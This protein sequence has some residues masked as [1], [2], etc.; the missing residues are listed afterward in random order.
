MQ[1]TA[2]EQTEE[3]NQ[4]ERD[5][6]EYWDRKSHHLKSRKSVKIFSSNFGITTFC[7]LFRRWKIATKKKE[8][9]LKRKQQQ[10][11]KHRWKEGLLLY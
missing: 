5:E 11:S 8:K 1:S 10:K 6:E 4:N 9:I 2:R 7:F 3:I